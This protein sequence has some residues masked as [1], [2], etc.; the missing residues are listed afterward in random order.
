VPENRQPPTT[1][2]AMDWG[3][4]PEDDREQADWKIA[5]AAIA[6]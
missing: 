5:D 3:V 2:A 4:F 6:G 1:M